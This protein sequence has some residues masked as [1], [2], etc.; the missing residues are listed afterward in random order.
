MRQVSFA[1]PPAER[2]RTTEA[3]ASRDTVK[4]PPGAL[5]A[6]LWKVTTNRA[7]ELRDL[8]QVK[9]DRRYPGYDSAPWAGTSAPP[10]RKAAGMTAESDPLLKRIQDILDVKV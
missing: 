5:A 10:A 4:R 6:Q 1:A 8:K 3:K 2:K 7:R 9:N